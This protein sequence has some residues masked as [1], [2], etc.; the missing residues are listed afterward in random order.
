MQL[1]ISHLMLL[2]GCL[3][4]GVPYIVLQALL[5]V[6]L[7][8]ISL[9]SIVLYPERGFAKHFW[10]MLKL[11]GMLAFV[12]VFVVISYGVVAEPDNP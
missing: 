6:E 12:M 3:W 1:A 11:C 9:A 10:D 7:I 8:L 5:A 2:A 4:G